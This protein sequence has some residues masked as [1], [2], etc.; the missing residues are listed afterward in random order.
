M[1]CIRQFDIAVTLIVMLNN[2]LPIC[3]PLAAASQIDTERSRQTIQRSRKA[4]GK[5]V[6]RSEEDGREGK[7][8]RRTRKAS[9]SAGD[10]EVKCLRAKSFTNFLTTTA[11][12]IIR[13]LYLFLFISDI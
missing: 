1:P 6:R 8:C 7:G 4:G 13:C 10:F 11:L 5:G 3:L 9:S 12:D 2:L